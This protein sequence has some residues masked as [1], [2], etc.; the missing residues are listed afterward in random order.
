VAVE[1][2]F[3]A[4]LWGQQAQAWETQ[5]VEE[6]HWACERRRTFLERHLGRWFPRFAH[7]V[8]QAVPA[9]LYLTGVDAAKAFILHD[10]EAS[11]IQS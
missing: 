4:Y 11:R 6:G 2:E 3:P 8:R 1:L 5:A 10:L 7:Q 9:P